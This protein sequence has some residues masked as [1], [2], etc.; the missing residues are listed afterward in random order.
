MPTSR[1]F[2]IVQDR[3]ELFKQGPGARTVEAALS[4]AKDLR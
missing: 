1:T 2:V 3:V 4:L